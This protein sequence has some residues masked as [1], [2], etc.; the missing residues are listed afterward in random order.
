MSRQTATDNAEEILH[1]RYVRGNADREAALGVAR[2]HAEIARTIY[3]L[4]TEAGLSQAE[5]ARKVETTQSVISRIEDE[6]YEGHSVTLL[7]RI[8]TALGRELAV[9]MLPR[10]PRA[11][12]TSGDSALRRGTPGKKPSQPTARNVV[13]VAEEREEYGRGREENASAPRHR[14]KP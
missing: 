4:R 12:A 9:E 3:A 8:A 1:R 7:G 11:R 10:V 13:A 6:D 5:L 14:S 2:L